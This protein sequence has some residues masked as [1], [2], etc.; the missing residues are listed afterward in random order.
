MSLV[1][2]CST[3]KG[4]GIMSSYIWHAEK[5][6]IQSNAFNGNEDKTEQE[7]KHPF[8]EEKKKENSKNQKM[9]NSQRPWVHLEVSL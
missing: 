4:T 5:C 9:S 1:H 7:K 2:S 3:I 6:P 8:G